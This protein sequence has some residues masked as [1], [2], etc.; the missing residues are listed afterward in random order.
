[1]QSEKAAMR[2]KK[3]NAS[4]SGDGRPAD[5]SS[6]M[7]KSGS[8]L[9]SLLTGGASK[10]SSSQSLPRPANWDALQTK[11]SVLHEQREQLDDQIS[12]AAREGRFE[13]LLVLRG[14]MEDVCEEIYRLQ[15]TLLSYE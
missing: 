10:S 2:M 14:A 4:G 7:G 9:R 13:E 8:T 1:M 12:R 11:L 3:G 5:Q 15:T 6:V